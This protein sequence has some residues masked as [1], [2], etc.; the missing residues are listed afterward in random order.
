MKLWKIFIAA[1]AVTLFDMVVA[2]LTCCSLF[3][4]VYTLEPTFVWKPFQAPSPLF[5]VGSFMLTFILADVYVILR[6]GIP[7]SNK[8]LRGLNYGLCVWAVG[9]LP[10]MFALYSF[11]TVN[12][13]V[14]V[15]WTLLGVIQIPLEGLIIATIF[16][17]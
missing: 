3:K 11:M 5:Y 7:G 14:V 2:M 17:E 16:G 10:G 8:Y 9:V 6:K 4:W 1:I 12:P 13:T 15:Y